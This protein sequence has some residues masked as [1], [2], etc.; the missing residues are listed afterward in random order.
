MMF[1]QDLVCPSRRGRP[2]SFCRPAEG[3]LALARHTHPHPGTQLSLPGQPSAARWESWSPWQPGNGMWVL[4]STCRT[5]SL[6]ANEGADIALD[7]VFECLAIL[8]RTAVKMFDLR[9][10]KSQVSTRPARHAGLPARSSAQE[11]SRARVAV[12]VRRN[13]GSVPIATIK[14]R[15]RRPRR[16]SCR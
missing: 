12:W 3:G 7:L 2:P 15:C 6:A 16:S 14:T 9:R 1:G 13:Q 8:P 11:V 4:A 5:P 10:L